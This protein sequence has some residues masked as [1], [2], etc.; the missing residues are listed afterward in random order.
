MVTILLCQP[1]PEET[2]SLHQPGGEATL[3]LHLPGWG[4]IIELKKKKIKINSL[5][6]Q[7]FNVSQN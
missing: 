3:L 7:T 2:P 5:L 4:N 1:E 6:K